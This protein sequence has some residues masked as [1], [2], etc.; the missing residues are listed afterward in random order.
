M[1]D[2]ITF[3]VRAEGEGLVYQ[4][5][6]ST[7]G[8]QTWTDIPGANE[9]EYVFTAT[10]E[11]HG[12]RFRCAILEPVSYTHL[13]V[14]KRQELQEEQLDERRAELAELYASKSGAGYIQESILLLQ[15]YLYERSNQKDYKASACEILSQ[16]VGIFY[17]KYKKQLR[18]IYPV[19]LTTADSLVKH[20]F[21][22]LKAL[23]LIHI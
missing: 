3:R 12:K 6:E 8:G 17:S 1:G 15:D 16:D 4:W 18:T 9:T 14:Y 7:D 22:M 21:D 2:N 19:F 5:Q 11:D 10:Q 23:S 13:D 20:F